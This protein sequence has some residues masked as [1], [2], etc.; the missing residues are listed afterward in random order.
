MLMNS[1]WLFSLDAALLCTSL[2][3]TPQARKGVNNDAQHEGSQ[4]LAR[5]D[6]VCPT[7][8]T[9]TIYACIYITVYQFLLAKRTVLPQVV[10]HLQYTLAQTLLLSCGSRRQMAQLLAIPGWQLTSPLD[11]QM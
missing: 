1:V 9:C 8:A 2:F 7:E 5:K 10:S 4:Q 6:L 3:L 11:F